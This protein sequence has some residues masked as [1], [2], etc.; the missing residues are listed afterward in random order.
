V[1]GNGANGT[2]TLAGFAAF[3]VTGYHLPG[4][5]ASDWLDST[6]DCNGPDKCVNGFF[7]QALM[8]STGTVG[9]PYLGAVVIQ[10]DE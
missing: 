6:Q 1:S 7:I 9:G 8:P 4:F 5:T 10:I 3:V 2:Y